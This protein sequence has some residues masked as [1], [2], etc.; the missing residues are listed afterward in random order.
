MIT[1]SDNKS[2]MGGKKH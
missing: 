1:S 2:N